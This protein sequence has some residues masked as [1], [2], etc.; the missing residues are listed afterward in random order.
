MH[1]LC[2]SAH[3]LE[4]DSPQNSNDFHPTAILK[5]VKN[6]LQSLWRRQLM[7]LLS[8][9][10]L[11]GFVC[12]PSLLFCLCWFCD[13]CKAKLVGDW[14]LFCDFLL[15]S[16]M[17]SF[18]SAIYFIVSE[19][20]TGHVPTRSNSSYAFWNKSKLNIPQLPQIVYNFLTLNTW[21]CKYVNEY[22]SIYI[23]LLSHSNISTVIIY[24]LLNSMYIFGVEFS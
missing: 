24:N 11:S 13:F 8:F 22:F 21:E 6:L 14:I 7:L 15:F 4:W 2:S 23:I 9:W 16:F 10:F 3:Y 20:P 12:V 19:F 5:D 1:L 17:M 18:S